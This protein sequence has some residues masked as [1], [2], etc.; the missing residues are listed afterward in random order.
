MSQIEVVA[1]VK[2]KAGKEAEAAEAMKACVAPSRAESTNHAYT[3]H[4]DLDA[5]DTMIFIERWDSRE[6]LQAHMETP[7]FKKMAAI[8]EPLLAAPLA[9]H[10]LQPL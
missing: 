9:V 3:P 2:V 10:I 7:H 6:A 5:P 1:I 4:R 8:L